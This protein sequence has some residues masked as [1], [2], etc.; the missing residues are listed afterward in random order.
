MK[1]YKK[2]RKTR[3]IKDKSKRKS[4]KKLRGGGGLSPR[5]LKRLNEHARYIQRRD[6][7]HGRM[8]EDDFLKLA[9]KIEEMDKRNAELDEASFKRR[10]LSKKRRARKAEDESLRKAIS[11]IAEVI[12]KS[13]EEQNL[14][15]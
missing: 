1:L 15:K 8:T 13:V 7:R 3:R 6:D 12:D 2:S 10:E 14:K 5:S 9:R 11:K 4:R